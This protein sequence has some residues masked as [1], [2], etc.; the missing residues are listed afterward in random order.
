MMAEFIT[1]EYGDQA[2]YDRTLQPVRNARPEHMP[3]NAAIPNPTKADDTNGPS[4]VFTGAASGL[5]T[6]L[7]VLG[8][9]IRAQFYD[10][11]LA[12]EKEGREQTA[13]A[14]AQFFEVKAE[15]LR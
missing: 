15:D 6:C 8:I 10:L 13:A 11:L 5:R 12:I 14:I 1:I 9:P 3:D 4:I 7:V 2:G